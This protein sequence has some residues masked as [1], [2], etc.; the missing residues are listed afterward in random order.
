LFEAYVGGL[1]V[2]TGF[3]PVNRW[4]FDA[5]SP[6]AEEAYRIVRSQYGIGDPKLPNSTPEDSSDPAT[7]KTGDS[8][9]LSFLNQS[10]T[11]QRKK[12][13]W[14]FKSEGSKTTP[15]HIAQVHIDKTLHGTGRGN[16]KKVAKNE[17]A[18]QALEKLG[19]L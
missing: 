9:H 18:R 11:Q 7:L 13:E 1:F 12:T 4:L 8:G 19:L 5:L 2:E 17:A 16:T 3:E 6:Y 14:K 10:M 15:V